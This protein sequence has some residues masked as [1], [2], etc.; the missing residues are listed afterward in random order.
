LLSDPIEEGSL[1]NHA[2]QRKNRPL[3][4]VF[5]RHPPK[6]IAKVFPQRRKAAEKKSEKLCVSAPLREKAPHINPI[7]HLHTRR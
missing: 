5:K 6:P 3:N 1:E 2:V 7:D 4:N